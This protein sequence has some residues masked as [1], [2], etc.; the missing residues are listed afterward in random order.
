VSEIRLLSAQ[1][2]E[3]LTHIWS[4]AYPGAKVLTEEER[5]RFRER[6]LRLHKEDPT[7]DFYGLFRGG[8][9]LGI[10][11]FHDLQINFLGAQ[12]PAG[13][14]G[15]LA[16]D[17]LH[18]KEHVAKEMMSYFLR[19]YRE[20]GKPIV[21][22]YPFRPDFYVN[23]GFGYGP[24]MSQ[25]RAKPAT[26]PKGP[27]KEHVR[28]LGPDDREAIVAC[29]N[30]FAERTHGMMFK[31]EREMR[32][33]FRR[34]ESQIVGVELNSQLRG[35]LVYTFEQGDEFITNNIH[36]Q[37]WIYETPEALSELLTFLHTQADQIRRIIVDTQDEDFHH[38]LLDPRDGSG[39]LI[40]SVYHQSNAQGVGLMVRVVDVPGLLDR[41]GAHDFGGQTVTLRLAV[42]DSFLPENAGSTLLRFHHGR[43]QRL[44]AGEHDVEVRLGIADLSSLLMGTVAFRSVHSYGRAWV[45]DSAYVD[46]LTD[47]FAVRQ[48]PVCMTA[49]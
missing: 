44:E 30:R 24:K 14:V 33:L 15:Q 39:R 36:I 6:A 47:A 22:L 29:Y 45:S 21:L 9:L 28:Y 31:T 41:L 43:M 40:P 18:K 8:R 5:E 19:H 34:Q 20:R 49:F 12:V 25:Y 38:L 35:Y 32:G 3:A 26:F 7:S 23:M 17:L 48:K 16:V 42:E 27:T 37:E 11:C 4:T 46:V 13:G 2:F 1:D 10:M